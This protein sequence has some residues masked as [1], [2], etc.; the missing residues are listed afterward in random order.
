MTLPEVLISI[1]LMGLLATVLSGAITVTLRQATSTE[2]RAN[3]A[4]AESSIDTWLPAD[5]AS[6]DVNNTALPAVELDPAATPCGTCAGLDFTDGTNALQ[7]AWES[8][9]RI[10]KVQYQY[11]DVGGEWQLRRI[12][13][14]GTKQCTV[15][16]VLHDLKAPANPSTFDPKAGLPPGILDVGGADIDDDLDLDGNAK[17]IV[18][19]IDG[20]GEVDGAG[21][22]TNTIRLTAGG[23]TTEEIDPDD[24]TVP[25]FVRARSR[26]GGPVTLI[27][28]DSG[29][30]N[31]RN[32]T[33]DY[34]SNPA[35]NNLNQ[36]VKP[37]VAAFIEAFRGTPTQ[38]QVIQFSSVA[39]TLGPNT[40]D[41][42]NGGT[43]DNGGWHR[44]IDMTNDAQVDQ[45]KSAVASSLVADGGTNW[46]EA[47]FRTF[48]ESNGDPAAQV[49]NRLVFFT[50]GIPTVSRRTSAAGFSGIPSFSSGTVVDYNDG[51]YDRGA[52]WPE[53][54][55]STYSQE[56]FDRA[57]IIFDDHRNIDKIFVGV[58]SGLQDPVEWIYNPDVYGN[59]SAPPAAATSK[60]GAETLS[61]LLMNSPSGQVPAI[62]EG[63]EYTNPETADFYLQ[64]SFDSDAF[65]KAMRAAALKDCGGTLT[66]QTRLTGGNSVEDEFVFENSSYRDDE[67]NLV[68]ADARRVTT[69]RNFRTGTFD[70]EI[71]GESD[72]FSVDV[73]PSELQTLG[74][75]TA[76]GWSCRSGATPKTLTSIPISGSSFDGFTVNVLANEAV[77]CILEVSK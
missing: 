14:V 48:K 2:G 38:L 50:D 44:Y 37:G 55:G 56:S 36:V 47:F 17:K 54:T 45:L 57:D 11:I 10:T 3:V 24:F 16:T 74:E 32:G 67:G 61:Y 5:L 22:G 63:G 1:T 46:E 39:T 35:T 29:S 73:V 58:G 40:A 64:Q 12:S 28:D 33:K 49:P 19:T 7:L 51:E 23:R 8:A 34:D 27:V 69:S 25:S 66:V 13:C 62:F 6:T 18:V 72:F 9:G 15:T 20:G 26:C 42:A 52:S 60:T 21:G 31:F 75:Y 59:R 30:I 41:T 70:F 43:S 65:G 71:S 53:Y 4:R 76:V 77:S 68:T